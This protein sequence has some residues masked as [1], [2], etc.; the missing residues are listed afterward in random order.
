MADVGWCN[1]AAS[2]FMK[3][4]PRSPL[5]TTCACRSYITQ[6]C[7]R[8]V[9]IIVEKKYKQVQCVRVLES[10]S[11]SHQSRPFVQHNKIIRVIYI[12]TGLCE[13]VKA[14][15]MYSTRVKEPVSSSIETNPII[16]SN[17][18]F[19]GMQLLGFLLNPSLMLLWRDMDGQL[20]ALEYYKYCT[21]VLTRVQVL[22]E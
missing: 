6:H 8:I 18:T 12:C 20:K 2:K 3:I 10:S 5:K 21:V 7:T 9:P 19:V 4:R 1:Q 17:L 11:M 15:R 16:E 13:P 14:V 22:Y